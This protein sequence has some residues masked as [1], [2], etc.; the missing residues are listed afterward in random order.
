MAGPQIPNL[1]KIP[2]LRK[3]ILLTLGVLVLLR[4]GAHITVPG[5]DRNAL[6]LAVGGQNN[7]FGLLDLFTGGALQRA[8]VFALGV[9][10]YISASIIFQLLTAVFPYFEKLQ[11]EGE[12]GYAKI[13]QYTRYLTM[14]LAAL[15][16]LGYAFL[17]KNQGALDANAGRMTLIVVTL[18]V[19]TAL[20]APHSITTSLSPPRPT[21]PSQL[22]RRS[23]C[24][25]VRASSQP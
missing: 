21:P 20:P 12:A 22:E 19:G 13:N 15:Q 5:V 7:L 8:T 6:T 23:S 10:P 1:F 2:E 3:K 25:L 11:K 18:T 17:F 4:V 14:V 9:M 24:A 16:A